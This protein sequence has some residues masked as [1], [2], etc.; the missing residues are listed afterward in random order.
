LQSRVCGV[1]ASH[2]PDTGY[3]INTGY[4]Y[5]GSPEMDTRYWIP[6]TGYGYGI[7]DKYGYWILDSGYRIPDTG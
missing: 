1:E 2:R 5:P 3:R 4:Q 6:V 7:L